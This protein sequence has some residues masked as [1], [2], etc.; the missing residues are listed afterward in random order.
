M[1]DLLSSKKEAGELPTSCVSYTV[2]TRLEL[3]ISSVT[4]MRPK[5]TRPTDHSATNKSIRNFLVPVN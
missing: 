2:R 4:G 3:V 5:P 1:I